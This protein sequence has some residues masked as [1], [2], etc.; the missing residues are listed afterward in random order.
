MIAK[1]YLCSKYKSE[2]V[3]N[4]VL[5]SNCLNHL[6]FSAVFHRKSYQG[7][8]RKQSVVEL[9]PPQCNAACGSV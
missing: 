2:T 6:T 9:R 1:S 4:R 7:R 8:K 3:F 5:D